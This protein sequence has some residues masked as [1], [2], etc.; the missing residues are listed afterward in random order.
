MFL[1]GLLAALLWLWSYGA[2]A[3]PGPSRKR[4]VLLRPDAA[5]LRSAALSLASWSI[6]VVGEDIEPPQSEDERAAEERADALARRLRADVVA[7]ARD[8]DPQ[9]M[10]WMYDVETRRIE[11]SSVET[12]LPF[13][14]VGAA[15]A[16][17]SLKAMLRSSAVAPPS[18]RR[19]PAPPPW[20]GTLRVEAEAGGRWQQNS[21]SEPRGGLGLSI[22]PRALRERLGLGL[23]ASTGPGAPVRSS[24]IDAQFSEVTFQASLRS[25]LHF[26][27]Q[28][29][30][31]PELGGSVHWTRFDGTVTLDDEPFQELRTDAALD[32]GLAA[33]FLL[34]NVMVG[35]R[36]CAGFLLQ[37]Q[38]YLVGDATALGSGMVVGDVALRISAG[39]F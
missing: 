31:E 17:L 35:L 13:D 27:S 7:W 24:S 26:G 37:S 28:F 8:R 33:D 23:I 34:G 22:W 10:I 30:L 6:D 20:P 1:V 19:P 11:V 9:T 14:D 36:A 4:V 38:R 29:A 32:V 5:W 21:I 2:E 12:R 15:A 3:A 39:V 16:A 18:E 25:R